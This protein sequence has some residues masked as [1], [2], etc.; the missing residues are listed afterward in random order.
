MTEDITGKVLTV[1]GPIEPGDLG[2]TIMHEHLFI[3]LLK[4]VAPDENTP[5]SELALWDQKLTLKNLHLARERKPILD[6]WVL[7]DEQLAID[8]AM[9]YRKMGGDTMVE[10]T[11]TGI[12]RDPVGLLRVSNATGLNIV[13]GAGWY[14]KLYH[15]E[16]MDERTVEDMAEEIIRDITVGVGDTG[17]RSGIIGEVGI[18]GGPIEPNEVK[19]IR[20]SVRASLATGAAISFH[21]GGQGREKLQTMAIMDEEG[22]DRSRVIFGHSDSSAADL[23][24]LLELLEHGVYVQFDN[25]G[26]VGVP[27]DLAPRDEGIGFTL[28]L[29]ALVAEAIPK[30]I[31]AGYADRILLSQDVCTKVQLTAY[32]GS[33]YS[34][35]LDTIL[36]HLR[37]RGVSEE[38][39]HMMM[40]DNPRRAL[41]FTEPVA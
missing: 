2:T 4:Q 27:L 24:L 9:E 11:S 21:L 39:I 41:T 13:M 38:Q 12:H 37:P 35:I 40:V 29:T 36:P 30:L 33:G 5:T 22:V 6:N 20:A 28:P 34:Y 19:S 15:P 16:N 7:S 14:Q 23:P 3:A 26:R 1:R 17:I 8:E 10:V 31:E 18:Q 32:G 25:M